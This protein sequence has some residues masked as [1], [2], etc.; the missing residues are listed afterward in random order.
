MLLTWRPDR[1][2]SRSFAG[3]ADA[4]WGELNC[5]LTD[6]LNNGRVMSRSSLETC[7]RIDCGDLRPLPSPC[8][9]VRGGITT[10]S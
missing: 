3:S 9:L 5:Q 10:G 7:K 2:P 4:A 6:H 1:R 8:T